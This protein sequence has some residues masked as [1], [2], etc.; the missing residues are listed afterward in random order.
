MVYIVTELCEMD[1]MT[2]IKKDG[3]MADTNA[4]GLFLQILES[5]EALR[6]IGTIHRDIKPENIFIKD[7]RLKLGDFGY[8]IPLSTQKIESS[9][10]LGTPL[11]MAPEALSH[12]IYSEKS[13]IWSLGITLYEMLTGTTPFKGKSEQ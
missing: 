3:K 4:L 5:Y 12:S 1:L 7:N 6:N 13:D 11:Y 2:K 8:S 9:V 10:N